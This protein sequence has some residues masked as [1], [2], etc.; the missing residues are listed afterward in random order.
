MVVLAMSDSWAQLITI[1]ISC[2]VP[3][4]AF[5]GKMLLTWLK[6]QEWVQKAH[7]ENFFTQMVPTLIQWVES[8]AAT[9]TDT[10]S[11]EAKMEKF[12]ELL[13]SN[14]PKGIVISDEELIL[15]AETE[16]RKLKVGLGG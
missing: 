4:L 9:Q 10:P 16:L 15:R 5:G 1:V 3:I 13:K 7:L 12:K 11:G 14:L 2:L 8:W 6:K